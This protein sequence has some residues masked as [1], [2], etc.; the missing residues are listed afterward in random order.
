MSQTRG[1]WT[2]PWASHGS[3]FTVGVL[4]VLLGDHADAGDADGAELLEAGQVAGVERGEQRLLDL[5]EQV[6]EGLPER[7]SGPGTYRMESRDVVL[8]NTRTSLPDRRIPRP[9]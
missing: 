1:R 7:P 2:P 8:V 9:N 5:V 4:L 3:S 6:D